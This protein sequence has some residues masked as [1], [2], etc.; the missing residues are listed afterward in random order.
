[1]VFEGVMAAVLALVLT[2]VIILIDDALKELIVSDIDYDELV[3]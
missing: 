1:M 3:V 2:L